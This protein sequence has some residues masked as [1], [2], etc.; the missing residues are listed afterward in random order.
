MFLFP[1][2][3]FFQ[4]RFFRK[5]HIFFFFFGGGG[6][7]ESDAGK[8]V[9][10]QQ[11]IL[12]TNIF[13]KTRK[14]SWTSPPV[15]FSAWLL[16]EKI[17]LVIF[18]YLTKFHCLVAF[19]SWDIWHMFIFSCLLTRLWRHKLWNSLFSSN[20]VVLSRPKDE[21]KSLN[22]LTTKRAFKMKKK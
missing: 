4:S 9:R 7:W 6:F 2:K 11:I 3:T 1:E 21:H 17:F 22:I 15:S 12:L 20:Q 8:C 10:V 14:R 19:T 13:W 16:K 5:I 18:L